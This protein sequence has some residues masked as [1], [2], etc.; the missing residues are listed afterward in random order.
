MQLQAYTIQLC[1]KLKVNVY[2]TVMTFHP[3]LSIGLSYLSTRYTLKERNRKR[4][5]FKGILRIS[6]VSCFMLVHETSVSMNRRIV[7]GLFL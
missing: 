5:Q 2:V 1:L 6:P 3:D 7:A 4:K